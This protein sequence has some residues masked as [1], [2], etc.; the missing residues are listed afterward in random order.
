MRVSRP[1]GTTLAQGS[2]VADER[3]GRYPFEPK[4]FGDTL[5]L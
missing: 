5:H 3:S 4:V 1:I 2:A